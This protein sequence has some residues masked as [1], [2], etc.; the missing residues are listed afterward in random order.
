MYVVIFTV[1]R[2]EAHKYADHECECISK[3]WDMSDLLLVFIISKLIQRQTPTA[4]FL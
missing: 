2:R 3:L 4:L 1:L